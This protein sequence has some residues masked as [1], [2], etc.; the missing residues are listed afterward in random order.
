MTATLLMTIV[1][2]LLAGVIDAA[3]PLLSADLPVLLLPAQ[4]EN[5]LVEVPK[6]A[7]SDLKITLVSDMQQVLQHVLG[8]PA[9]ERRLE[10]VRPDREKDNQDEDPGAGDG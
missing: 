9:A 1:A 5:D 6:E 3:L 7:L 8:E 4:N 10:K 2:T